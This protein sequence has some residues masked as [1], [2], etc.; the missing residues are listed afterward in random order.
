MSLEELEQKLKEFDLESHT[1]WKEYINKCNQAN[2]FL[3]NSLNLK[4]NYFKSNNT[5]IYVTKCYIDSRRIII[6]EG[7]KFYYNISSYIDDTAAYWDMHGQLNIALIDLFNNKITS[8][9]KE[10]FNQAFNSMLESIKKEHYE[11]LE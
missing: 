3:S 6:L 9:T 8:I 4:G 11:F 10:E 7:L 1:A 2:E 5:Y